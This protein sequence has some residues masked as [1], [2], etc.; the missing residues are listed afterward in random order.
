MRRKSRTALII[1]Q[2]KTLAPANTI[3]LLSYVAGALFVA[4]VCCVLLTV[5]YATLQTDLVASVRDTEGGITTL[6]RTYYDGVEAVSST[7]PLIQGYVRPTDVHYA[8]EQKPSV[9]TFAGR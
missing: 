6:E 4:Y 9:L 7:N 5:Y 2:A 3:S 1:K 8:T